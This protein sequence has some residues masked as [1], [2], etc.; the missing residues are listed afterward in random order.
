MTTTASHANGL[1]SPTQAE[2]TISGTT[3]PT[4]IIIPDKTSRILCVADIRGDCESALRSEEG[5]GCCLPQRDFPDRDVS[6]D[7]GQITSSTD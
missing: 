1:M 5:K 7:I 3:A 2:K 4:R 6:A